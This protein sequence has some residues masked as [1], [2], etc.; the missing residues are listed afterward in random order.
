MQRTKKRAI[1]LYLFVF[2]LFIYYFSETLHNGLYF[3]SWEEGGRLVPQ[4]M[5]PLL[6]RVRF[7]VVSLFTGNIFIVYVGT[8]VNFYVYLCL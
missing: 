3:F 5:T 8:N 6:S 7:T 1:Y 2:F 4:A